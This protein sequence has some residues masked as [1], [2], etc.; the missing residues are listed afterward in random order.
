MRVMK[1]IAMDRFNNSI[2]F[3]WECIKYV[4][5]LRCLWCLDRSNMCIDIKISPMI[6]NI[7]LGTNFDNV[8]YFL[9]ISIPR[10]PSSVPIIIVLRECAVEVIIIAKFEKLFDQF[11]VFD[12][13]TIGT[14]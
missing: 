14:Q 2:D 11:C 8:S 5:W 6:T 4:S 1:N 10:I 7:P 13:D 3:L 12:I 9:N